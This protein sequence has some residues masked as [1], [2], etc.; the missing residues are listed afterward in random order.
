MRAMVRAGIEPDASHNNCSGKHSGFLTTAVHLGLPTKGYIQYEHPIQ[1]RLLAIMEQL[2]DLPLGHA[3]RGIDG[4]G[5]P[6]IAIPIANTARAMAR[7]ARSR[8]PGAAARTT[9]A[10]RIIHAMT[11]EPVMVSG[12]GEFGSEVM[13][14]ALARW[15]SSPGPKGVYA[16]HRSR[17][18]SWH[19]PQ[20]R[21]RHQP[22]LQKPPWASVLV[23]LGVLSAE[24][25]RQ[26]R[27]PAD[28]HPV[29]PRRHENRPHP[30]ARPT[31]LSRATTCAPSNA[32]PGAGWKIWSCAIF[33]HPARRP[34]ARS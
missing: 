1:Q 23:A 20:G 32:W 11:A 21:G 25:A 22:R 12:T 34:R 24:R 17:L 2:W 18:G 33:Q 7:L 29:E 31:L 13:R 30:H 15:R 26:P 3:P 16:G 5:I 27:R 9:A 14:A 8:K 19:L 4:C 28:A 10:R 6:T